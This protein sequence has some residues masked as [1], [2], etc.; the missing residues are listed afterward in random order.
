VTR[1]EA[2][3][4]TARH[5]MTGNRRASR[6]R[7]LAACVLLSAC[8]EPSDQPNQ[9]D[10]NERAVAVLRS[11]VSVRGRPTPPTYSLDARMAELEVPGVSVAVVVGG[12]LAWARG[13]GVREIGSTDS[14]STTTLFQAASISKPIAATAILRMVDHGRLDLD[15]PVNDYLTSWKLPESAYTAEQPV[16]LRHLLSHG[17][18]TTVW[19]FPGYEPGNPL[20]T[21]RQILDGLAPANTPPVRVDL[22]PGRA[23]RYSGGG[24]TIAQLVLTDV[25]GEAFSDVLDELVLGPFGMDRS[26]FSQPLPP[27]LFGEA[28]AGHDDAGVLE[29]RWRIH[30]ELAAAGLWTTPSDLVT[31]AIEIANAYRGAPGALLSEDLAREML[32]PQ[33]GSTGLGPSL[34]GTGDGS[35]FGHGGA[36]VGFRAQLV[37]FPETGQGAAVM[38][39]A[40]GGAQLNREILL[41]LGAEHGWPDYAEVAPIAQDSASLTAFF[42]TFAAQQL[43]VTV[44][45]AWEAGVP[46]VEGVGALGHQEVVFISPDRAITLGTGTELVFRRSAAGEVISLESMGLTMPRRE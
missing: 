26:T 29:G 25:A 34:G 45:V 14:V 20:P 10:A 38:S 9:A 2:R 46:F 37:Y 39:N 24:F 3:A 13:F 35:F 36:N 11:E 7:L 8:S 12:R 22:T 15:V 18:G 21:L 16:T 40:D 41:A 44:T 1:R 5:S 4:V 42:G 17:A 19:G 33:E 43:P 31:W 30:P 32:T 27:G 23:W 28:A 6:C